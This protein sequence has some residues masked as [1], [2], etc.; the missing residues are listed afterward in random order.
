VSEKSL[1]RTIRS[2]GVLGHGGDRV[3]GSKRGFPGAS[4]NFY[5]SKNFDWGGWRGSGSKP[6]LVRERLTYDDGKN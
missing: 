5:E 6:S 1:K 2:L 3:Q 4:G